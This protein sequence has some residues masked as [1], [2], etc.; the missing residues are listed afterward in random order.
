MIFLEGSLDLLRGRHVCGSL[1][2]GLKPKLDIP[3]LVDHYLKKVYTL[4]YQFRLQ[5]L[6]IKKYF[7]Y[8]QLCMLIFSLYE[9]N[10]DSFI[11]HELKFEEINKAF[12]LLVQGKSLRCILWMNK[13]KWLIMLKVYICWKSDELLLFSIFRCLNVFLFILIISDVSVCFIEKVMNY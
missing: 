3:I 11:T 2:G 5:F 7:T 12:D 1:F 4:I 8:F 13:V 9:L 6:V 10:L